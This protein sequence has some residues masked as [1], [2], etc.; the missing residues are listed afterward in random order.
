MSLSHT[1]AH[2]HSHTHHLIHSHY[3]SHTLAH[4]LSHSPTPSLSLPHPPTHTLSLSLSPTFSLPGGWSTLMDLMSTLGI[5]CSVAIICFAGQDLG[6]FSLFMKVVIFLLAEQILLV[7]K[8][9]IQY[10]LPG[11][12]EWVEEL[13]DRNTHIRSVCFRE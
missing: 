13:A 1:H 11:E 7:Y 12:A 9:I 3:H 10:V 2:A 5:I 6:E 4:T 8:A